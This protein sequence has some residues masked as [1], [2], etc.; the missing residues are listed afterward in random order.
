MIIKRQTIKTNYLGTIDWVD[1]HIVDWR[2]GGKKYFLDGRQE[3]EPTGYYYA[4]D[5]DGSITSQDGKYVLLYKRLGTKAILFRDGKMLREINRSYYHA[6][7]YEYPAAFITIQEKT[8]LAHCPVKYRQLDFEDVE[9]GELV[10][11]IKQRNPADAFHSRLKVSADNK[12]LLVCGWFWHP[13]DIVEVYDIAAYLKNPLLLDENNS[14]MRFGTEINT[15]AFINNTQILLGSTDEEPWDDEVPLALPQKHIAIWD[16]VSDHLSQPAKVNDVFGNLF[17]I[18][19]QYAWDMYLFPKIIHI[20]T[21]EIVAKLEEVD[22]GKQKSSIINDDMP[23]ISFNKKNGQIAV[24]VDRET[25]EVF[26]A[27]LGEQS[28]E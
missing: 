19:E 9:T 26:G 23:Q 27:E 13:L 12:Y 10:T 21:G 14:P 4:F 20:P 25:I 1:D 15:A 16:F 18:N 24:K 7:T 3:K 11:N 2:S 28:F 22:T 5:F 17:A 8:Y 6:E